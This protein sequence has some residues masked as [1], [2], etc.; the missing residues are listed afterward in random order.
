MHLVP[1]SSMGLGNS[2]MP[3]Q[4]LLID[5][6]RELGLHGLKD[7]RF[8]VSRPQEFRASQGSGGR[9]GRGESVGGRL[10]LG[11]RKGRVP[12]WGRKYLG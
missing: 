3:P 11:H 2:S 9:A 5:I 10:T 8:W 1:A 12:G 6:S 7:G 4:G